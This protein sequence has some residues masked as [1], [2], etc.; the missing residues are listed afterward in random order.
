MVKGA[1]N[2][3]MLKGGRDGVVAFGEN[4]ENDEIEGVGGVVGEAEAVGIGSI[5]KPGQELAGVIQQLAGFHAHV[6]A[7]AAR[8]DASLAI[9]GVHERINRF[10]LGERR[11]R[12]VQKDHGVH[13]TSREHGLLFGLAAGT[14]PGGPGRAGKRTRFS[15]RRKGAFREPL[16]HVLD[17]ALDA[18]DDVHAAA[19]DHRLGVGAHGA[20]DDVL[21]RIATEKVRPKGMLAARVRDGEGAPD[22]AFVQ[23]DDGERGGAPEVLG[24][25]ILVGR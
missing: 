23:I 3:I 6:V 19:P 17:A 14:A 8:V 13:G 15:V 20:G 22:P 7:R 4:S 10:G 5:E 9:K 25:T 16:H 21:D 12:V 2:G 24:Y 1:E 18:E 11:R